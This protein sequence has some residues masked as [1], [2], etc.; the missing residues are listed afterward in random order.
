MP[1]AVIVAGGALPAQATLE[2][3]RELDQQQPDWKPCAFDAAVQCAT[4]A[5]P[6]DYARPGA[7]RISIAL[8]D[9]GDRPG[10]APRRAAEQSGWAAGGEDLELPKAFARTPRAGAYDL[11]GFDP[12]GVGKSTELSCEDTV[13]VPKVGSRPADAEPPRLADFARAVEAACAKAGGTL[14]QHVT[15]AN[16][17]RDSVDAWAAW[18]GKRHAAFGL[19]RSQAEVIATVERLSARLVVKPVNGV[20]QTFF[21]RVMASVRFRATWKEFTEIVKQLADMVA[22][23][24]VCTKDAVRALDLLDKAGITPTYQRV[25]EAVLCEADWPGD[26]DTYLADMRVFREKYPYGLGITSAAPFPCTFRSFTPKEQPIRLQRKGYQAGLVIQAEA[27]AR[28]HYDGGPAL[29]QRPGL[30]RRR[31]PARVV[32]E[33]HLRRPARQPLPAR[34]GPAAVAVG[35]RGRTASRRARGRCGGRHPLRAGEVAG[36]RGAQADRRGQG[37]QQAGSSARPRRRCGGGPHRRRGRGRPPR[38]TRRCR[39]ARRGRTASATPGWTRRGR[40]RPPGWS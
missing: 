9:Q 16:T 25:F 35:L 27:D 38:S 5:V 2:P 37:R 40:R 19:G 29:A 33:Q 13:P 15:T 10:P 6:M 12:R 36:S 39:S 21:D 31:G 3:L 24:P 32:P 1:S 23:D 26:A 22:A 20:T 14:R 4:I 34:L 18:V 11:I 17:A 28:T 7:G 8:S 30:R